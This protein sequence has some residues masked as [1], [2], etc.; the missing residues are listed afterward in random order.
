MATK[1]WGVLNLACLIFICIFGIA[2][3]DDDIYNNDPVIG[4]DKIE[5]RGVGAPPEALMRK[6]N[7]RNAAEMAAM[8]DAL[9]K[10][11]EILDV[12]K[13]TIQ[14]HENAIK[15]LE[16][17]LQEGK[18]N[19]VQ[20]EEEKRKVDYKYKNIRSYKDLLTKYPMRIYT[21]NAKSKNN[22][23][24]VTR[25]N[26]D[27]GN[28]LLSTEKKVVDFVEEI[29]I[30]IIQLP[31]GDKIKVKDYALESSSYLKY[32]DQ[33]KALYKKAGLNGKGFEY[34]SDGSVEFILICKAPIT[35]NI[36]VTSPSISRG[37]KVLARESKITVLG[38]V[39]STLG[40]ADVIIN[41]QTAN[42]DEKG[43]FSSDI[44]LRVGLNEISIRATDISNNQKVE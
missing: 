19:I 23:E 14:D 40:V 42:L 20:F 2:N 26:I 35:L 22:M 39:I 27:I 17:R 29:D 1:C 3:A 32:Y 15:D 13:D 36:V 21:P 9:G 11:T 6:P 4:K 5:I 38:K 34:K 44:L 28:I 18:L 33:F 43:N 31:G 37:V 10:F 12:I 7:A 8:V 25:T 30:K 24:L 16:K 41:G